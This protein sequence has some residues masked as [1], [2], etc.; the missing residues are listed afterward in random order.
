MKFMPENIPDKSSRISVVIF[1]WGSCAVGLWFVETLYYLLS[2]YLVFGDLRIIIKAI[3]LKELFINLT[4][5]CLLFVIVGILTEFALWL[6]AKR[7]KPFYSTTFHV[8]LSVFFQVA[9]VGTVVL[10]SAILPG[11]ASFKEILWEMGLIF[12]GILYV[13]ALLKFFSSRIGL[14][15]SYV[16]PSLFISVWLLPVYERANEGSQWIKSPVVYLI[17]V[18]FGLGISLA[19]FRIGAAIVKSYEGKKNRG[20]IYLI[21]ISVLSNCLV[22]GAYFW[23]PAYSV[24]YSLPKMEFGKLKKKPPNILLIVLDT[25]RADHLSC[26]GNK[27]PTTPEI[28]RIA[29]EGVIFENAMSVSHWTLPS[30]ASMFT[31]QF[32]GEHHATGMN[33]YLRSTYPTIAQILYRAGYQTAGF[34]AN[35]FVVH[36]TG[37]DRGFEYFEEHHDNAGKDKIRSIWK[38]W[39]FYLDSLC[40]SYLHFA[41]VK[42]E[43]KKRKTSAYP[44]AEEV[45]ESVN[46]WIKNGRD[47]NRPFFLFINLMDAHRPFRPSAHLKLD[48]FFEDKKSYKKALKINQ[49]AFRYV[50][51]AVQMEKKDFELLTKLYDAKIRYADDQLKSLFDLLRR[52]HIW[53]NTLVIITSD[54]GE[55]YG[56]R[57]FMGHSVAAGYSTL[58]IPL[59]IKGLPGMKPGTNVNSLTQN[60][61]IFPT[62]LNI[63]GVKRGKDYKLPG[64]SLLNPKYDRTGYADAYPFPVAL[65]LVKQYS[66]ESATI[67]NRQTSVIWRKGY[68]YIWTT[69]G[70][71]EMYYIKNDPTEENNLLLLLPELAKEL[72]MEA[73]IRAM[74]YK[75]PDRIRSTVEFSREERERLRAL[76]YIK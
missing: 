54:H 11:G 67:Y 47:N 31:G 70:R 45:L 52:D 6:L 16:V 3:L 62:I 53:E 41:L 4:V 20:V 17:F 18:A 30:H 58:R 46:E 38:K 24:Q 10:E 74:R 19:L 68:E 72:E 65:K 29:E 13:F 32:P 63:I 71:G 40:R 59:I 21:G 26:Y 27:H 2:Q 69:N 60:I 76:G 61:D 37:L 75:A 48:R 33:L 14:S 43:K 36:K 50:G 9:F 44:S 55:Y 73:Q 1:F 15:L 66:E 7:L 12:P 64:Y 39:R 51:G 35:P 25:V 56:E 34:S 23:S 57:H 5:Y 49:N 42:V 28:D 22:L 8:G